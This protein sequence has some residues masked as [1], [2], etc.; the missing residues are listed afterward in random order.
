MR[1]QHTY[2]RA[3]PGLCSF[4]EDAPNPQESGNARVFRGQVGSG[5]GHP[6]GDGV[7]CGGGVGCGAVGGLMAGREWNMECGN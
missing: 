5:W 1:P 7:G 6:S 2:S 3:L 4:R